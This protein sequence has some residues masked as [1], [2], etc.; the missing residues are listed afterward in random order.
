MSDADFDYDVFD[1]DR[2]LESFLKQEAV[3]ESP[4]G[5]QP[6][7]GLI[8]KSGLRFGFHDRLLFNVLK[9]VRQPC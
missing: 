5:S 2:H 7:C 9:L 6:E 8:D 3:G 4:Q 1:V